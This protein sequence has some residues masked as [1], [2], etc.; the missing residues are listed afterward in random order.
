MSLFL[1][2]GFRPKT[3]CWAADKMRCPAGTHSDHRQHRLLPSNEQEGGRRKH[4]R[5][6]GT[7]LAPL[8]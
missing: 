4:G 2:R 6:T 5:S 1:L 7:V 8:M 3:V